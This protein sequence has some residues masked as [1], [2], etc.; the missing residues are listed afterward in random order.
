M[1]LILH[2]YLVEHLFGHSS[3]SKSGIKLHMSISTDFLKD[4]LC[5]NKKACIFV[6]GVAKYLKRKDKS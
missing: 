4:L 2:I 5:Q 3:I 6:E 1:E